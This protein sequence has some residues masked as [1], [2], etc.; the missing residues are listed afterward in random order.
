MELDSIIRGIKDITDI[1]I[2]LITNGSLLY[3]EEIR[4]EITGADILA[5][6]LDAGDE[7]TF[8]AIN[9][10]CCGIQFDEMV[11]GIQIAVEEFSGVIR[12]ETMLVQGVNTSDSQLNDLVGLIQTIDP[13]HVDI[14]TPVRPTPLGEAGL[15][16]TTLLEDFAR[17]IGSNAEIIAARP[18]DDIVEGCFE[19]GDLREQIL[20]MISRR[21]CSLGDISAV[22]GEPRNH[23]L[24]I[25]M[26]LESEG[27]VDGRRGNEDVYYFSPP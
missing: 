6:S 8:R 24:K 13:D 18:M 7:E 11:T 17:R 19:R 10:P 16:P 3:L 14:N 20:R 26:V 21:P 5:P 22:T 23:I 4:S 27:R 15:C 9:H 2:V 25:L 12:L 1:P